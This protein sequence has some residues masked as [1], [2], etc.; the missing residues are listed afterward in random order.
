M[1]F[2]DE[3]G[4]FAFILVLALSSLKV[5]VEL[6]DVPAPLSRLRNLDV[7]ASPCGT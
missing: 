4:G 7:V 6:T 3:L 1:V 2:G 5:A